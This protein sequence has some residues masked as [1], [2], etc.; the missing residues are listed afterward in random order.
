MGDNFVKG[1]RFVDFGGDIVEIYWW[2]F[3][4]LDVIEIVLGDEFYYGVVIGSGWWVFF[5]DVI[6]EDNFYLIKDE[7]VF[8][9]DSDGYY[10]FMFIISE[11]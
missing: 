7:G 11:L 2:F 1:V 9:C 3:Y 8:N 4:G 5:F 10:I 6:I